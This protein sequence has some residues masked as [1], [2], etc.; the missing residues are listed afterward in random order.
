[1]SHKKY[2][3]KQ[4]GY[5]ISD[6]KNGSKTKFLKNQSSKFKKLKI[7]TFQILA[8]THFNHL[9]F[10]W[11]H[12]ILTFFEFWNFKKNLRATPL[13]KRGVAG[14]L[15]VFCRFAG[16]FA[17]FMQELLQKCRSCIYAEM[18]HLSIM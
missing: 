4:T 6:S 8:K 14:I 3:S 18:E 12:I 11:K 17:G 13:Q 10:T 5:E 16:K 2:I 1:M 7:L 9:G 15:Q